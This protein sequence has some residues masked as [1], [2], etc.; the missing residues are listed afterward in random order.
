MRVSWRILACAAN[1]NLC[2]SLRHQW[3]AHM[4]SFPNS[5]EIR[6]WPDRNV[7]ETRATAVIHHPRAFYAVPTEGIMVRTRIS[8]AAIK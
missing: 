5:I 6:Q 1:S 2:E 3:A 4:S 7:R 8:H